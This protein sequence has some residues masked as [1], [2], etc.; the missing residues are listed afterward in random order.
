MNIEELQL[1][2]AIVFAVAFVAIPVFAAIR[3]AREERDRIEL[4][5][6]VSAG[7]AET[8]EYGIDWIKEHQDRVTTAPMSPE[9]I[10]AIE[11]TTTG[12]YN[13]VV[14]YTDADGRVP[15][16]PVMIGGVICEHC[17]RINSRESYYCDGCRASI[18][19]SQARADRIA[20]RY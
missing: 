6:L 2:C 1:I 17:G 12:E 3:N 10:G 7:K 15:E 16:S 8:L 5:F 18:Y 9:E 13:V 4:E 19:E 11:F 20:L 14:G